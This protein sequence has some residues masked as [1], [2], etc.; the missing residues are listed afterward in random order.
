MLQ[1]PRLRDWRETRALTQVELAERAGVSPRSVAGYEAG[2]GARPPTVRKLA[3]ALGVEVTDLMGDAPPKAERGASLEPR[4]FNGL[5]EEQRLRPWITYASRRVEWCEKVA[6][7]APAD[8]WNNPW[9]SLDSAIQWALYVGIESTTLRNTIT[10]EA[11]PYVETLADEAHE[12]RKVLD[13]FSAVSTRTDE[14]VKAMMEV[15]GMDED[16]RRVRMEVIQGQRS[17]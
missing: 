15:A 13:R 4:L 7:R 1:I 14:R 6:E 9:L 11:L 16:E 5:E 3:K 10:S 12:L 17:A 2:G 8:D